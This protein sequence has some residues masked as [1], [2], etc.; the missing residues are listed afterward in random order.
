[1]GSNHRS[2]RLARISCSPDAF[3][4]R[5]QLSTAPVEQSASIPSALS[6]LP[7]D[8]VTDHVVM[9]AVDREEVWLVH[10]SGVGGGGGAGL[11]LP[12]ICMFHP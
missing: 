5:G 1:M 9:Q 4:T 6:P 2:H 12:V 7:V 3:F 8:H 11:I 10:G